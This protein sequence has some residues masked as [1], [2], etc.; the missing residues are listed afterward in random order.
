ML[1]F[2]C[3]GGIDEVRLVG[4]L[5]GEAGGGGVLSRDLGRRWAWDEV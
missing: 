1:G 2:G 5:G 4:F 3:S